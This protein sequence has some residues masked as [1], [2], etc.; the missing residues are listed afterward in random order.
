MKKILITGASRG[1]GL[2]FVRQYLK[3]GDLVFA[4]SRRSAPDLQA[5][6]AEAGSRLMVVPLDVADPASLKKAHDRIKGAADRLDV[7]VNNAGIYA[8]DGSRNDEK[9][10]DLTMDDGLR[11]FAVNSVG[12]LLVAQQFR[13]LLGKGSVV[14][15][16]TSGYGSVSGNNGGFPYHYSASKAALNQYMRSFSGDTK[17]QGIVTVVIDPGWVRTDMGGPSA[18]LS[19]EQSAT[20]IIGVLDGL[21]PQDSG[22]FF[23]YQGRKRDW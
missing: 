1:I 23:D 7:L 12:P 14:A 15:S 2:E 11:V 13:D 6:S 19:T 18:T 5:L 16:I 9:L 17:A 20:G 21:K 8:A 10:G 4:T 3:R 22:S